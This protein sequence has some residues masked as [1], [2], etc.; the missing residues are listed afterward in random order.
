MKCGVCGDVFPTQ[1]DWYAHRRDAHGLANMG[2]PK[3]E[4]A[5]DAAAAPL[6]GMTS[7]PHSDPPAGDAAP[8]S[9]E[10]PPDLGADAVAPS[11]VEV[12]RSWR[13]RLWGAGAARD[14]PPKE[15]R[16]YGK[17][18][19]AAE[20]LS[21]GWGLLGT[22]AVRTGWDPP[23][24]RCMQFQAPVAGDVLDR[25]VADTWVDRAL[26]QPLAR[27]ADDVEAAAALFAMPALIYAYE[28]APEDMLPFLSMMMHE[29]MRAH[30]TAMVPVV[31]K[32]KKREQEL[33]KVVDELKADGSLPADADGPD[34]AIRA[35]LETIF[36]DL[37]PPAEPVVDEAS[38]AV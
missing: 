5:A 27:H 30:L 16:S 23:V 11:L 3:K 29:A 7:E 2:R 37:R 33:A 8:G 25:L 13:D 14:K 28:R 20:L 18:T 31:R 22:A 6:P 21:G 17:R 15:R 19:P 9:S 1:K 10:V 24:G 32:R 36:A 38:V 12:K 35:V 4:P 26:V 34:D